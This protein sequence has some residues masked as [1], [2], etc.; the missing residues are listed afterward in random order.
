MELICET[1][2]NYCTRVRVSADGEL[3][4]LCAATGNVLKCDPSGESVARTEEV[5]ATN[6]T[7][8]TFALDEGQGEG[9][10][11]LANP[12]EGSVVLMDAN[13]CPKT[14]FSSFEAKPFIGPCA[15]AVS[16]V[17]HEVF[18]TDGGH[19]G[20]TSFSNPTGAIYR[21][22]R[23]RKQLLALCSTGLVQPCGIAV[24]RNGSVFVCEQGMNRL[25]RFA[26]RGGHYVGSVFYQFS[27]SMGPTD[28]AVDGQSGSI[29][30]TMFEP[31]S[32]AHKK[33]G[34]V[35]VL[36]PSGKV[37]GEI[38]VPST[39]L[40]SVALSVDGRCAY[41]LSSDEVTCTSEVFR[42]TL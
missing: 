35:V 17:D 23:G 4:L 26:P 37:S 13:A 34:K 38:V 28:V 8:S 6:T 9:S 40:S 31:A 3:F 22:V 32:L 39:Q 7:P 24:D 41:I 21:T 19:E 15:V 10:F 12:S 14:L 33:E 29:F 27:G 42:C 1:K 2:E 20:D 25:L 5:V 30:V 16:P 36:D 11:I 18:F